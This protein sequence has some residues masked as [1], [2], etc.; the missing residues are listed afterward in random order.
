MSSTP[1]PPTL[2]VYI[3]TI[4]ADVSERLKF[5]A[6]TLP[7]YTLRTDGGSVVDFCTVRMVLVDALAEISTL[8]ERL[9]ATPP[10]GDTQRGDAQ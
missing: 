10:S 6:A 1:E 5:W 7:S 2:G 8:R 4:D 3:P 9:V